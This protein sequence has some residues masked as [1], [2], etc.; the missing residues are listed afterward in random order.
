[1]PKANRRTNKKEKPPYNFSDEATKRKIRRHLNDIN[2]VITDK[3]IKNAKVPGSEKAPLPAPESTVKVEENK[4]I[5]G[6]DENKEANKENEHLIDDSP[7]KPTTS[8]DILQE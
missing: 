1:M 7:G 4:Q 3:D 5:E 6:T 8:W 2:D